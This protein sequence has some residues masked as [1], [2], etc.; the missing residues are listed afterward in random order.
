M[1]NKKKKGFNQ[2][3][4]QPDTRPSQNMRK[5]MQWTN[6]QMEC[7]MNAV[8]DDGISA[9]KAAIL[10]RVPRS[11]LKDRLSGRVIHAG[12]QPYLD[13]QE[14]K[15][16]AGH[17]IEA[18]NIGYGKTR[19]EVFGIVK[20][21]V[22]QKDNVSLRSPTV[23]HGWWQKFLKRNPTL[24]LRAG[25][26]TA[27]IRMDAINADNLK[28]F[29]QLRKIFDDYNFDNH[30]EA[31]YN[32]DETGVPLEPRPPKVIAQ[33]GKKKVH[34]QT[35]SGQKQQITVIGCGSAIGQCIPPFII[36][37]AKRVNHMWTRNKVSGSRY[38]SS[39]SGWVDHDLFFYFIQKH[40]LAH[41][42][43]YRPLMLLLDDHST[44]GHCD[45]T[46]LK[47]ARDQGIIIF[48]LPPHTT[49]K[50]QPLDCSLFKPLKENWKQEC[51]KFYS[52]NPGQVINKLNFN[53]IFQKA[54]LKS[55][56]PENV[57]GF[58]KT[59]VYPFN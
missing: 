38:T 20:R 58:R 51:H 24:S 17:L 1:P 41:A 35:G 8:L 57:A 16:L 43:S 32:M 3:T 31:I 47:F 28:N 53:A 56:T 39:E 34:Y 26:S 46:S 55:V 54:W 10:H 45:L 9:N 5:Q 6:E 42:V 21:Y 49:H 52:K 27:S 15:E 23:T 18:S 2:S 4:T 59:G 29:D 7:A 40:F 11:T 37:A 50:C 48:C 25:D 44:H 22:E 30:P 12:P 13:V 19:R 33:E 14:E 36:F